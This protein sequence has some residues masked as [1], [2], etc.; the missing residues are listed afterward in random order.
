MYLLQVFNIRKQREEDLLYAREP[1]GKCPGTFLNKSRHI[2]VLGNWH[3]Q[4][5]A[6]RQRY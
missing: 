5:K 4:G 6:L 3:E 1:Y 2:K